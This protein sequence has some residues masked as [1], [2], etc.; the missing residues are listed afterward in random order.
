M[1]EGAPEF[2]ALMLEMHWRMHKRYTRDTLWIHW[3]HTKDTLGIHY[4]NTKDTLSV[5]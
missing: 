1:H 2:H 5:H 4:E 3:G